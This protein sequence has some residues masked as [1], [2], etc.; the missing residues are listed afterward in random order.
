M[1]RLLIASLLTIAMAGAAQAGNTAD[2][3]HPGSSS[4]T[5]LPAHSLGS[6][7][8]PEAWFTGEVKVD[9]LFKGRS[10]VYKDQGEAQMLRFAEALLDY[11]K[12]E[13]MPRLEG[14]RMLMIIAPK[15]Q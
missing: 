15:K 9:M 14:K 10:I 4:Q 3:A 13:V 7:A 8:G 2:T 12:P 11:G 6:F 1:K 5:V